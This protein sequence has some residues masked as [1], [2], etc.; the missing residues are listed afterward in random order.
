V[1]QLGRTHGL[2]D[3][4]HRRRDLRLAG[5]VVDGG[6]EVGL[7]RELGYAP[8]ARDGEARTVPLAQA[9][10]H[11]NA[12]EI[13]PVLARGREAEQTVASGQIEGGEVVAARARLAPLEQVVGEEAHVGLDPGCRG[14]DDFGSRVRAGWRRQRGARHRHR[15]RN[16]PRETTG[17]A[18]SKQTAS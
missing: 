5:A 18:Q 13:R 10:Q 4:H 12:L 14:R 2:A 16:S 6:Q 11:R 17:A 1:L 9:A 3:E 7:E 8:I 15:Q